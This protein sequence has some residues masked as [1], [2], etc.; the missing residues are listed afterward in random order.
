MKPTFCRC[1]VHGCGEH[2]DEM[3]AALEAAVYGFE[4]LMRSYTYTHVVRGQGAKGQR[5]VTAD[6][7]SAASEAEH[8]YQT[9]RAKVEA[10]IAKARGQQ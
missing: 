1:V 9:A 6:D 8:Q 4:E 10:A 7:M 3:L 2:Y 5:P